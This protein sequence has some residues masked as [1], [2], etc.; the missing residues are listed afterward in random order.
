MRLVIALLIAWTVTPLLLELINRKG[1]KIKGTPAWVITVVACLVVACVV[2]AVLNAVS[3]TPFDIFAL[4]AIIFFG[5]N[6]F[7]S[8]VIKPWFPSRTA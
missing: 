6:A 8:L 2:N 7:F 3:W 5:C 1:F 4:T